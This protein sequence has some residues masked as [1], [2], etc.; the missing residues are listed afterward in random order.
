VLISQHQV[1]HA[2]EV[3]ALVHSYRISV[4]RSAA[5]SAVAQRLR[6][7]VEISYIAEGQTTQSLHRATPTHLPPKVSFAAAARL[8]PLMLSSGA[9]NHAAVMWRASVDNEQFQ[10]FLSNH[11]ACVAE[12]HAAKCRGR[13][14]FDRRSRWN[15]QLTRGA[16]CVLRAG[17]IA[18][19]AESGAHRVTS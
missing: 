18:G 1:L 14:P 12:T 8:C 6:L 9:G 17:A 4:D 13:V 7:R 3:N 19:A 16:T 10:F 2:G 5:P 15:Q 11:H